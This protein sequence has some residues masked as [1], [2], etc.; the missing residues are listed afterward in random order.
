MLAGAY[1]AGRGG[2]EGEGVA[3]GDRGSGN[4]NKGVKSKEQR[5][6]PSLR[7]QAVQEND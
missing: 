2:G 7:D 3:G 1:T 5:S 6:A 4:K